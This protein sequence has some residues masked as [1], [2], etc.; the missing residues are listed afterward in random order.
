VFHPTCLA[1]P[2]LVKK[3]N[4]K[5]WMCVDY[6]SLNKACPKVPFL[7]HESIKSLTRPQG[8]NSC[9]SLT[10]IPGTTK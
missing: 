4:G 5:W 7:C 6:T 9:V 3:K 2:I 10:P 1:N 8:V